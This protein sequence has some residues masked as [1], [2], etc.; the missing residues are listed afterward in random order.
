MNNPIKNWLLFLLLSYLALVAAIHCYNVQEAFA[1]EMQQKVVEEKFPAHMSVI[2]SSSALPDSGSVILF[3]DAP[4]CEFCVDVLGKL[5]E[6]KDTQVRIARDTA[7][8]EEY[9]V[10][11][12]PTLIFYNDG[13]IINKIEGNVKFELHIEPK[14]IQAIVNSVQKEI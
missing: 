4:W 10:K 11:V 2:D 6:I 9:E 5:H 14:E 13:K 12:L 8:F 3:F 7:L 1:G